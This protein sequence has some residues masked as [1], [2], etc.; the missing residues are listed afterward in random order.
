MS[1]GAEHPGGVIFRRLQQSEVDAA[2]AILDA[3]AEWLLARGIRQW[4][5]TY[6]RELYQRAQE[7]GENFGLF[8]RDRVIAIVTVTT[9]PPEWEAELRGQHARWITK[10]AVAADCHGRGLGRR[11]AEEM[12]DHLRRE[13]APSAWLDCRNGPLVAFYESLGFVRITNKVVEFDT[14]PLDVVLMKR[15]LEAGSA[16]GVG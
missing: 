15:A 6:P 10:L 8:D 5:T 2:V 4:T 14:G 3:A 9:A 11:L 12:L 7:H 16:P 13:G 1:I